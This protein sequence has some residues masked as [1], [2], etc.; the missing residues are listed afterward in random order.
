MANPY[1]NT[2]GQ[3]V[4]L[5]RGNPPREERAGWHTFDAYAHGLAT[6]L[7]RAF[8]FLHRL[9]HVELTEHTMA[10][11]ASGLVDW[12]INDHGLACESYIRADISNANLLHLV[13]SVMVS[14]D[15]V[16]AMIERVYG[17]NPSD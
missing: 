8:T 12:V 13:D 9:D 16:I 1:I 5:L 17:N 2:D 11:V 15:D 7:D 3:A 6:S 10:M 4:D 14:D